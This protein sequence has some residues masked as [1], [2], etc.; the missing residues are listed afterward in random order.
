M[1]TVYYK[2]DWSAKTDDELQT[3][4]R[5]G[6]PMQR[7]MARMEFGKRMINRNYCSRCNTLIRPEGGHRC[8]SCGRDI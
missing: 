4:M 8:G 3:V 1:T 5:R 2:V 6:T 7:Q